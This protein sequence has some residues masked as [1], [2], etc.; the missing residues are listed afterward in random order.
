MKLD[1]RRLAGF[2]QNPGACRVVL[3]YGDD[4]GLI[5]GRGNELTRAVAGTLDDPFRVT[6]LER[7]THG[8]LAEEASAMALT[9]GR[10]VVRVRD[11]TDTLLKAVTG[12]LDGKSD[13]LVVLEAPEL[14]TKSKLRTLL[15]ASP[16]GVAIGC[17]PEEGRALAATIR[18]AL[19]ELGVTITPDGLD[20]V[21]G[22]LGAD[23]A[24]TRAEVEKLGLYCGPGGVADMDAVGACIGDGAALSMDEAL[25]AAT[26]GDALRAHRALRVAMAEGMTAVGVLRAAMQH[27]QR[28]HRA[29]LAMQQGMSA[30]EAASAV[31]P[32]VFFKRAPAFT[33]ALELWPVAALE[34]ALGHLFAAEAACKRTGAPDRTISEGALLRI[35]S[36]A[37][38]QARR[39]A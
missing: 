18:E 24:Q 23:R 5:R 27:L 25:F 37:A 32:P 13:A 28:L 7:E 39:R 2:L 22:L 6:S 34:D 8:Q 15:E 16:V 35:A 9:G 11:V 14:A 10:R 12:H 30:G 26:G 31:R 38:A 33:R 21:Q 36:R 20:L 3:L 1:A 17:Y 4:A 19:A 29:R